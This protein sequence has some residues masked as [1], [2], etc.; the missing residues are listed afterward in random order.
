MGAALLRGETLAGVRELT[1]RLLGLD[2]RADCGIDVRVDRLER[3]GS[4]LYVDGLRVSGDSREEVVAALC[5]LLGPCQPA[6]REPDQRP[7]ADTEPVRG[8]GHYDHGE[9]TRVE[10]DGRYLP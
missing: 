10:E 9:H 1:R 3:Q 7:D 4:L 6:T 5:G 8:D 2:D